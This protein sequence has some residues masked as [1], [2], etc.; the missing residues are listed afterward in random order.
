MLKISIDQIVTAKV[1]P[2]TWPD[3]SLGCPQPD[4]AY[5]QILTPGFLIN[6]EVDGKQ[7]PYHTDE[8]ESII[9][10]TKN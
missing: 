9:L 5:A 4:M 8:G 2:A 6:L 1:E 7:Y 10:C 3:A